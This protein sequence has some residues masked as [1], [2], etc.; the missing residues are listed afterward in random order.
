MSNASKGF[1]LHLG[2]FTQQVSLAT[3][4]GDRSVLIKMRYKAKCLEWSI[5]CTEFHS[6]HTP[7]FFCQVHV[8][9]TE[10]SPPYVLTV[11]PKNNVQSGA[12]N[13]PL[14]RN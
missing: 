7:V 4:H 2:Q 8:Y 11:S 1:V 14:A 5:H 12:V 6:H 10:S 13:W 9:I 3:G